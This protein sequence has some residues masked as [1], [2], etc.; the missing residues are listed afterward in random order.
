MIV[1]LGK[2]AHNADV[3]AFCENLLKI[4]GT[5]KKSTP[6]RCIIKRDEKTIT[7][8]G[9]EQST[10]IIEFIAGAQKYADAHGAKFVRPHPLQQMAREG[11]LQAKPGNPEEINLVL[12]WV[13]SYVSENEK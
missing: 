5:K 2:W 7:S 9:W 3:E 6:Q 13:H 8:V 10:L 11:W 1:K 12:E 4:E